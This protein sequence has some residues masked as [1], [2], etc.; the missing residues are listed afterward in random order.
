MK[1][2]KIITISA[3]MV[4]LSINA[5]TPLPYY[6]GFDTPAQQAGWQLYKLG[7]NST[8]GTWVIGGG[9]YSAPNCLFHDYNTS[10]TVEDWYV[11]PSL[12]IP[13]Q[14]KLSLKIKPFVIM[15]APS[16]TDYIGIW[17]SPGNP[18]PASGYYNEVVNLTSLAS[19]SGQWLDTTITL[20]FVPGNGY[21][22]FKYM[23]VDNWFTVSIDNV[24][25]FEI[26]T[27]IA[28]ID[29]KISIYVS[30]ASNRLIINT[31]EE[32]QSV[33]IF[34]L[35]GSEI[36]SNYI[37]GTGRDIEL[38]ALSKGSYVVRLRI[39]NTTM[40]KKIVVI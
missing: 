13:G 34:D 26:T 27:D 11:S 37:S 9:G 38:P 31:A 19:S 17:F 12:I 15:G 23:N 33:E 8:Y 3:L 5:Q 35:T 28:E 4:N 20:P 29:N 7:V 32:L 25:V 2:I 24:N 14:A 36:Y 40:I 39:M 1:L 6:S 22:G 18:D 16:A 21:I 30:P 10:G